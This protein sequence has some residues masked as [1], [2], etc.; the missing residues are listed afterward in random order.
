MNSFARRHRARLE[1]DLAPSETLLAAVRVVIS[2][3]AANGLE[4]GTKAASATGEPE[5]SKEDRNQRFLWERG[6]R[7]RR[8]A[9]R[10]R[11]TRQI[12]LAIARECGFE[13]PG[14]I[15]VVGVSSERMLIWSTST[16]LAQPLEL[17]GAVEPSEI[18]TVRLERRL[19]ASRLGIL[20]RKGP[21]LVVQPLWSRGLR[22]L[23]DA[24]NR[25]HHS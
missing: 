15:F 14:Q 22:T 1:R 10:G 17:A 9:A 12:R 16:W 21:L 20:L 4:F 24:F 2:A 8:Q 3:A 18:T 5:P 25:A 13:L 7:M 19:G 6:Q 11:G 23:A